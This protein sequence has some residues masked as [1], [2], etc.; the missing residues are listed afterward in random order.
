MQDFKNLKVWAKAH[1]LT[2]Q[3]Y[4]FTRSFPKE[5]L[6]GLVSQMRRCS[7]SIGANIAEGVGRRSD[8]EFG[9]FLHI[10]RGSASEL[11]YHLLLAKDLQFLSQECFDGLTRTTD[12]VQRMVTSLIQQV[13]PVQNIK[14]V[15]RKTV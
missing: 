9:R 10:A 3:V 4:R 5:E 13:Q 14:V 15:S 12:E 7:S 2:L 1:E 11:E 6:F 8:G